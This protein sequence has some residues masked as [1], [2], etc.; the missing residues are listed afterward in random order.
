MVGRLVA[1]LAAIA[2]AVGAIARVAGVVRA[3]ARLAGVDA[4]AERAVVTA[5]S[6]GNRYFI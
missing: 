6:V 3:D 4:V 5:R 1:A 2:I